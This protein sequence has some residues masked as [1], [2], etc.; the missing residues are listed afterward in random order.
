MNK[1]LLFP[2]IIPP[3]L[4]YR[5]CGWYVTHPKTLQKISNPPPDTE[6]EWKI[7]RKQLKCNNAKIDKNYLKTQ[8]IV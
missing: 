5:A 8:K 2:P 3:P 6:K 4:F 1:S 7:N